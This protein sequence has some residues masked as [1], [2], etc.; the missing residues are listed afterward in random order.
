MD[1]SVPASE[2]VT[3]APDS[4]PV[5][6]DLTIIHRL[7]KRSDGSISRHIRDVY[8]TGVN[9]PCLIVPPH[10]SP[11]HEASGNTDSPSGMTAICKHNRNSDE[12]QYAEQKGGLWKVVLGSSRGSARYHDSLVYLIQSRN[13]RNELYELKDD[14]AE[15][16]RLI[17]LFYSVSMTW[18]S[19]LFFAY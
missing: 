4:T 9:R 2:G 3:L 16:D 15:V 19:F 11:P 12:P 1:R 17:D 8:L 10:R 14:D 18:R 6:D 13:E 5:H 7:R